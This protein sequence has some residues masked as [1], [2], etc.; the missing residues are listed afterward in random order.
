MFQGFIFVG[1]CRRTLVSDGRNEGFFYVGVG[2]GRSGGNS[3]LDFQTIQFE[4][5]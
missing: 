1:V 5:V 2:A 4:I 3:I